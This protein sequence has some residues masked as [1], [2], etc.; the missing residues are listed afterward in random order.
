MSEETTARIK[1]PPEEAEDVGCSQ[2]ASFQIWS[3]N[4]QNGKVVKGETFSSKSSNVP[5]RKQE[6]MLVNKL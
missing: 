3:K 4:K 2:S 5:L 6:S 1:K